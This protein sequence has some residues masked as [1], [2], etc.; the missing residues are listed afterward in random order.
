MRTVRRMG[1]ASPWLVSLVLLMGGALADDTPLEKKVRDLEERLSD[2]E[3]TKEE[4]GPPK[5]HERLKIIGF[6][7]VT[8]QQVEPGRT[9]R[10]AGRRKTDAFGVGE[11]DLTFVG[12]LP[13]RFSF[14]SENAIEY[15]EANSTELD[16]ERLLLKYEHSDWLQLSVG[17]FHTALGW[18][19]QTY[20]HGRILHAS[21]ERPDFYEFEDDG[22]LL[23]VHTVGLEATGRIPVP[24]A[25]LVYTGNLANGRAAMLHKIQGASDANRHK[26][27]LLNLGVEPNALRGLVF[28]A[29]YYA[30]LIPED[31]AT[32]GRGEPIDESIQGL[33][34][35][36]RAGP[37]TIS[38]EYFHLEHQDRAARKE[39]GTD[40][41]YLQGAYQFKSGWQPYYRY[42]RAKGPSDPD[43]FFNAAG[44]P[45]TFESQAAGVAYHFTP[46]AVVKL[47]VGSK[48]AQ[49]NI[50]DATSIKLQFA[51]AF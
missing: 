6:A 37:W 19:N 48:N 41:G 33:Y 34:S 13:G 12:K 30:D 1:L 45:T 7:H 3:A 24:G 51:V 26:A 28:G 43:P 36:Y 5:W 35:A 46:Q 39:F 25:T 22:G 47:E 31:T 21:V 50:R 16:P 42:E 44:V 32:A 4:K 9:A 49:D 10:D 20:H 18:W 27:Y 8:Y 14:L 29:S 15:D 38:S 2:L 11:L 40:M 23:P 17:R